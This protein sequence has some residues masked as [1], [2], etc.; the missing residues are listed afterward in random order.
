MTLA[1]TVRLYEPSSAASVTAT[2]A[3]TALPRFTE[4]K[5]AAPA[6]ARCSTPLWPKVPERQIT[7][8]GSGPPA[9]IAAGAPGS[10]ARQPPV[11][12]ELYTSQQPL[13][14]P[15]SAEAQAARSS[16]KEGGIVGRAAVASRCRGP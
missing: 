16:R 2:C 6:G 15:T 1:K 12:H 13:A 7:P 3:P 4:P 11:R 14:R 9:G 8:R 10:P 5:T